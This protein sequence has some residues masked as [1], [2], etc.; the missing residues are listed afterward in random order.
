M[1]HESKL[2]LWRGVRGTDQGGDGHRL[3]PEQKQ[4]GWWPKFSCC[5]EISP[6][7]SV[8]GLYLQVAWWVAL[9]L[10]GSSAPAAAAVVKDVRCSIPRNWRGSRALGTVA[11]KTVCCLVDWAVE[12]GWGKVSELGARLVQLSGMVSL[13]K[14]SLSA[15]DFEPPTVTQPT[16]LGVDEV[17]TAVVLAFKALT[18]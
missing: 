4:A 18:V 12:V 9:L 5:K 14:Q 16:G 11:S 8:Q 7:T 13:V 2:T 10:G 15:G 17:A 3:S 6:Y 1:R